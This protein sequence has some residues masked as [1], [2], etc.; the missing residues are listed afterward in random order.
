MSLYDTEIDPTIRQEEE[1]AERLL[2]QKRQRDELRTMLNEILDERDARKESDK[3]K[4]QSAKA[5]TANKERSTKQSPR[6]KSANTASEFLSGGILTNPI[7][8]RYYPYIF[9]GCA[10][11][12]IYMMA[13][14][15]SQRQQHTNQVLTRQLNKIRTEAIAISSEAKSMSSRSAVAEQI[16][17]YKP[18]LKETNKPV[19][20]IEE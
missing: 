1:E 8:R 5:E 3:T 19:N 7:V 10:L 11:L 4:R 13:W 18:E 14:F 12:I 17:K 15:G 6:K 9:G 20:V 2:E 16:A